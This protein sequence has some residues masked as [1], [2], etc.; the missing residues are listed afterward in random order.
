MAVVKADRFSPDGLG[1]QRQEMQSS[2]ESATGFLKK[3]LENAGHSKGRANILRTHAKLAAISAAAG[4][5]ADEVASLVARI[6]VDAATEMGYQVDEESSELSRAMPTIS[7]AAADVTLI[8]LHEAL[9]QTGK[10]RAALD[11]TQKSARTISKSMSAIAKNPALTKHVNGYNDFD[12]DARTAISLSSVEAL[13][14][15]LPEI[16]QFDFGLGQK[17]ALQ[18]AAAAIS[19][20]FSSNVAKVAE[21]DPAQAKPGH[22]VMLFN[23][24]Y[25]TA[26]EVYLACWRD[27]SRRTRLGIKKARLAGA[28]EQEL[29]DAVKKRVQLVEQSFVDRLSGIVACSLDENPVTRVAKQIM[30]TSRKEGPHA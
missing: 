22:R 16:A 24:F 20:G 28:N 10:T 9:R 4:F 6:A 21:E 11:V 19:H 2:A 15:L 1:E 30:Q 17:K 29:A 26:A 27:E 12:A 25:R 18:V 7:R 8:Y 13:A 14:R 23:S 3:M 5:P